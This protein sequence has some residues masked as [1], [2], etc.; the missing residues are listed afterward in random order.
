MESDSAWS[1][2]AAGPKGAEPVS[3]DDGVQTLGRELADATGEADSG[4]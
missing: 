4:I 3:L 1:G 2:S